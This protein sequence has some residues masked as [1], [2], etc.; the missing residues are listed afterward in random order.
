MK[1]VY[2]IITCN[3]SEYFEHH[4]DTMLKTMDPTHD[5]YI[6]IGDDSSVDDYTTPY[7]EKLEELGHRVTLIKSNRRGPHYLVNRI[8]QIAS[9]EEFDY[10]FMAEDDIFFIQKEWDNLYVEAI[11]ASSFDYLCY[12]NSVW[13]KNHGRGSCVHHKLKM[14]ERRIQSEI[15]IF[16]CFGCFWTFSPEVIEDVGY[17]DMHN[18]GVWGNG[19]TD[20]SKRCCRVGFNGIHGRI[21]DMLGSEEYIDMQDEGYVSTGGS[22]RDVDSGMVGVPN[23]KHKSITMGLSERVYIPYNEI[24]LDMLGRI[25]E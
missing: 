4:M 21:F 1:L 24:N 8:L 7:V 15:A 3:R 16:S 19:H 9:K 13:A 12:F 6:I 18:L 11:Q 20:Y 5:W 14:P 23:G 22:G 17:F 25:V 10:G 2:G